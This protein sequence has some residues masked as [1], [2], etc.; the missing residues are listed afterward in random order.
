MIN[1]LRMFLKGALRRYNKIVEQKND[2]FLYIF[3]SIKKGR[4]HLVKIYFIWK[5]IVSFSALFS[6]VLAT[7]TFTDMVGGFVCDR[8]FNLRPV[9]DRQLDRGQLGPGLSKPFPNMVSS[10]KIIKLKKKRISTKPVL[11]RL[12]GPSW[13]GKWKELG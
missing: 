8:N 6:Q 1:T 11:N 10:A 12:R 5:S 7:S 3:H 9:V 4:N 13:L 2:S